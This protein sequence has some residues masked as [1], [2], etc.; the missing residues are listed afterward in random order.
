[1]NNNAALCAAVVIMCIVAPLGVA[2][3]YPTDSSDVTDYTVAKTTDI[4]SGLYNSEIPAY[5]YY[6]GTLNNMF[7][8]NGDDLIADPVNTTTTVGSWPYITESDR[9]TYDISEF[10]GSG[11]ILTYADF[12]AHADP[13]AYMT[14][15][16]MGVN[17]VGAE[18]EDAW[19][20]HVTIYP[21]TKQ[22][23]LWMGDG[24]HFTDLVNATSLEV[25]FAP[26]IPSSTLVVQLTYTQ[27]TTTDG[28]PLYVDASGGVLIPKGANVCW[29]NTFDNSKVTFVVPA[30]DSIAIKYTLGTSG[31]YAA[32]LRYMGVVVESGEIY[33]QDGASDYTQKEKIGSSSVYDHLLFEYVYDEH[34]TV[35]ITV[36]GLTGLT[37]ISGDYTDKMGSSATF[38]LPAITYPL[39]AIQFY[40]TED[41]AYYVH[42][43]YV[44]SGTTKVMS[45]A[46]VSPTDYYP[47]SLWSLRLSNTAIY[48]DNITVYTK[49]GAYTSWVNDGK[50]DLCGL[51][52]VPL[53][54]MTIE[55][56]TDADGNPVTKINGVALAE[57]YSGWTSIKLGGTWN[58]GLYLSDLDATT[59]KEYSWT[60]GGFG[61]D[62]TGFALVGIATAALSF[63]A[64]G[65]WG[66][67][68]GQKVILALLT[69]AMCG[70]VYFLML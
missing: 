10:G 36:T 70:V 54:G 50:I 14:T 41:S 53:R 31:S 61:L 6:S 16:I 1:M 32:L 57:E 51:S 12:A 64:V 47:D 22:M 56:Y 27:A 49:N 17:V 35:T 13:D 59:H 33:V 67:R 30:K 44:K 45:D 25:K 58:L 15:F 3:L 52:N 69:A 63:L 62:I 4:S 46:T 8:M 21:A 40:C 48:G 9:K 18:T 20:D 26:L 65:L 23:Y 55:N 2:Y 68:S 7:Q 34:E 28:K 29:S 19:H 24:G 60:A 5:G 42:S 38:R 66:Q 43:A 37:S 11:A 39:K